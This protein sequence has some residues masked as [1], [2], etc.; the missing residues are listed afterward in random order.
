MQLR[1]MEPITILIIL[2][3]LGGLVSEAKKDACDIETPSIEQPLQAAVV[4][5]EV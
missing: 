4:P 5:A 2:L 1:A 3:L